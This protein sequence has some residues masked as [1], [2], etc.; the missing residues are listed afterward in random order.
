QETAVKAFYSAEG[1]ARTLAELTHGTEFAA[2]V[3]ACAVSEP[4]K[5]LTMAARICEAAADTHRRAVAVLERPAQAL[6]Q[7]LLRDVESKEHAL[8]NRQPIPRRQQV[9]A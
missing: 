6:S 5:L 9:M 4:L 8:A 7:G 2:H 3:W 1:T